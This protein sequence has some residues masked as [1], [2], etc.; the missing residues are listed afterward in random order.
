MPSNYSPTPT[1]SQQS[2]TKISSK[3]FIVPLALFL[4]KHIKYRHDPTLIKALKKDPGSSLVMYS[5]LFIWILYYCWSNPCQ[6]RSIHTILFQTNPVRYFRTNPI[7]P[8]YII[9]L[10]M[11]F[12]SWLCFT[13]SSYLDSIKSLS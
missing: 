3:D 5:W 2:S 12:H 13:S 7:Y 6:W 9:Y 11:T 4:L 8:R 1:S 10:A